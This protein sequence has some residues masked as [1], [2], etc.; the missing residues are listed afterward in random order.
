MRYRTGSPEER[1][2]AELEFENNYRKI[3]NDK[4]LRDNT[5]LL[6]AKDSKN[7]IQGACLSSPCFMIPSSIDNTL[8]ID[9]LAVNK[10]Y[11]NEQIASHL[12]DTTLNINKGTFT[13]VFL[14]GTNF[15]EKFYLK[16]G[17]IPLNPLNDGQFKLLEIL[18]RRYDMN[19]Y[20][21]PF[22]K[23]LQPDKP[24]WYEII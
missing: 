19:K 23:V 13:D 1:K 20:V 14:T 8:W 24:R 7:R 9:S 3:F 15:A 5:T 22:T 4:R 11:R 10:T 2:E 21:I 17:F 18:S 16:K 12:L 6:V